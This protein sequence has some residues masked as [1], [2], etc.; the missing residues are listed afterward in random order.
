M[1]RALGISNQLFI[2]LGILTGQSLSFPWAQPYLWR[3]VMVVAIGIAVVQLV[4]SL[5][6]RHDVDE[7]AEEASRGDEET[8]LLLEGECMLRRG[9]LT[10]SAERK[11]LNIGQLL[12]SND[13]AVKRGC[14]FNS[15][16]RV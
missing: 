13:S 1:K 12:R 7:K 16:P 10:H 14:M 9:H 15:A 6:V 11:V 3:W 2:V 5:L 8:P 4:G